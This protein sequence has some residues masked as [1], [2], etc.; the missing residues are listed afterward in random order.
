MSETVAEEIFR[1]LAEMA[2][3]RVSNSEVARRLRARG[4]T[5]TQPELWRWKMGEYEPRISEYRALIEVYAEFKSIQGRT[6]ASVG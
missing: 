4:L 1:L 2:R 3:A 5:V 6:E